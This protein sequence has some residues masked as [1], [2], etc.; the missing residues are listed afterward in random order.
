[1]IHWFWCRSDSDAGR[2]VLAFMARRIWG[3]HRGMPAG[4]VMAILDG[5][6]LAGAVLFHNY[7]PDAG[8]IEMTAAAASK[9]WL[10]RPV[11]L[12]MFRYPF[13]QLGCQAVVMR[14]DPADTALSRILAAYG[15]N[16]Y[17]IPRLRGRNKA[18]ALFI[19]GDDQW[20]EN[21]FHKENAY[22]KKFASANATA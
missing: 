13:V 1:M 3:A 22:G 20:R 2:A 18:E 7:E 12:E 9:R 19:L 10:T 17:E 15:F 6:K 11:L 21:G 5:E 16:R 8:V 14:C 4:E